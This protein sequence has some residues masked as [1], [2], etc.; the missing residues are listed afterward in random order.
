MTLA[1]QA[2][3]LQAIADDP[4]ALVAYTFM[5]R[6]TPVATTEHMVGM[7][8]SFFAHLQII[9]EQALLVVPSQVVAYWHCSAPGC[10]GCQ[11]AGPP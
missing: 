8:T 6:L 1:T 4:V 2:I 5:A 9:V 11:P 10:N 7:A 3:H